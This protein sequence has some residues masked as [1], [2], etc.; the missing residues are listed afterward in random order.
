MVIREMLSYRWGNKEIVTSPSFGEVEMVLVQPNTRTKEFEP[1]L[2]I[3][4]EN[5]IHERISVGVSGVIH[6][7]QV[8]KGDR[9]IPGMVLAYIKDDLM[10]SV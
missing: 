9:V 7:I 2:T 4:T 3:K 8:K 6:S 10:E 5:G 1:L